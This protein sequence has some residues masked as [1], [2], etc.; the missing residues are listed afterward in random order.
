[1]GVTYDKEKNEWKLEPTISFTSD[2]STYPIRTYFSE[3]NFPEFVGGVKTIVN[4]LVGI[5]S[6]IRESVE[7]MNDQATNVGDLK[8][9]D[10]APSVERNSDRI[11]F[12]GCTANSAIRIFTLGGRLV[13][14]QWADNSGNAEVSVSNLK[15]GAYVVR[16]DN[17]AIIISK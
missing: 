7:K 15:T 16:S 10:I 1:M 17:A 2:D 8:V 9:K 14:T 11:I 3:N 5:A 12:T 6:T 4:E 13:S